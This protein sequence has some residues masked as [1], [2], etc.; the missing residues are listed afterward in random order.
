MTTSPG[1][2]SIFD[3]AMRVSIMDN[4]I[5]LHWEVGAPTFLVFL[6]KLQ[7]GELDLVRV[8]SGPSLT[9]TNTIQHRWLEMGI[10]VVM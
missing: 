5:R 1:T 4:N 8:T 2:L 7:S 10:L 3:G 6:C 9:H